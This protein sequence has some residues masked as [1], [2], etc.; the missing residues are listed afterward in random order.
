MVRLTKSLQ[1]FLFHFVYKLGASV[2]LKL[3]KCSLEIHLAQGRRLVDSK[4]MKPTA[5]ME[6]FGL[7]FPEP[8]TLS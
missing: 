2:A 8:K 4:P 3:V 6:Y 5:S 7:W 1:A